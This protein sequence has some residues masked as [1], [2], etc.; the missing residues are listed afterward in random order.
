MPLSGTAF[1]RLAL[2][3]TD[4]IDNQNVT[5][6]CRALRFDLDAWLVAIGDVGQSF[7]NLVVTSL[8]GRALDRQLA[9]I[10][11]GNLRHHLTGQ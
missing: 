10:R 11:H 9:K 4:E 3:S 7:G 2:N 5:Q 1:K 8:K 6:F